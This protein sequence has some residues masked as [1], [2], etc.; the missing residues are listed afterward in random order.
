[1]TYGA[2]LKN[3]KRWWALIDWIDGAEA[4][5]KQGW[6]DEADVDEILRNYKANPQRGLVEQLGLI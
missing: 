6:T 3:S 5:V 1:L 4:L 2:P